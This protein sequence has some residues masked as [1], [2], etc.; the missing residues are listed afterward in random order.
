MTS[1]TD[2]YHA[3][4]YVALGRL[5]P[6]EVLGAFYA[7]MKSDLED[8]GRPLQSFAAQGPLLRQPAIEIYGYQYVPMLT[9]LWGLTPRVAEV[10]G[11]A[12]MPTYAYFRVYQQG[13]VCRVHSD[14]PSCEHSLSLTMAYAE[15]QPWAL[16]VATGRTEQ[17]RPTVADD[18]EGQPFG[19][20]AMN[21]GDGLLYQGTHHRHGR[22]DPNPNS[23][24]MHL[25]LHWVEK[26]GRYA[27][28][29]FDR[30]TME[31]ARRAGG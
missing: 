11:R 31:Q 14:R 23:W 2:H 16:S 17:P 19:S 13:D 4:G 20:V 22:L 28:H 6:R 3:H 18:F 30:P 7:Q 29:A 8:A 25:F 5:F 24:S 12:L 26:S 21:A 10:V 1:E 15:D 27:E 9:F